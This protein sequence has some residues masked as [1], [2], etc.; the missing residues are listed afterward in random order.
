M[1]RLEPGKYAY[2]GYRVEN[3]VLFIDSTYTPPEHRGKGIAAKLVEAAISY[4]KENGLRIAANCDYAK[5]YFERHPE[6]S[7]LLK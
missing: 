2:L 6:Y 4:S 7:Q 1:I 5:K 3:G